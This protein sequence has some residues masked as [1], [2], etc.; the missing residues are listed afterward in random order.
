MSE[1]RVLLFGD[2]NVDNLMI[3]PEIPVPGRDGLATRLETHIG[4]AVVNT[5]GLLKCMGVD[6]HLIGAIGQDFWAEYAIR[7]LNKEGIVHDYVIKSDR[8]QTGLIFVAVTSNG[9]RT[10][11]SYRGVNS[12]FGPD[13]FHSDALEGTDFLQI[14]GYVFLEESTW[15]AAQKMIGLAAEKKIPI[16]LDTG[17]DP[18]ILHSERFLEILHQVDVLITGKQEAEQL[19]GLTKTEAQIRALAEMGPRKVT[20]KYGDKG[21]LLSTSTESVQ[22]PAASVSVVDTT[23]AGD[24]YSAGIVLGELVQLPLKQQLTLAIAM[25]SKS[26]ESLGAARFNKAE[27]LQFLINQSQKATA[28]SEAAADLLAILEDKHDFG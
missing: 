5:A 19:T 1:K 18:V 24:A 10:M 4:G 15:K 16:G 20:L 21:A 25:G 13:D 14:S 11:L 6:A 27:F 2:I 26:T 7:T 12:A 9:E 17:L 8:D 23:G 3:M 22:L 28:F